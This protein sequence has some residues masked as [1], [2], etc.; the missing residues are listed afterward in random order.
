ME[1]IKMFSWT[2]SGTYRGIRPLFPFRQDRP[3]SSESHTPTAEMPMAS[4][5]GSPGHGQM[6][7]SARPPAPG[8]QLLRVGRCDP[9]PKHPI[10][11]PGMHDPD[12]FDG[13]VVSV[14]E[15]QPVGLRPLLRERIVREVQAGAVLPVG[16]GGE[17]PTRSWIPD[18]VLHRLSAEPPD[19]DV[20]W[21]SALPP[22]NEQPLPRPNEHLRVVRAAG[23]GRQHVDPV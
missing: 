3:P 4:R 7:W 16:D 20:H 6:E 21:T 2:S 15:P 9:G 17:V 18:R 11:L 1:T 23:D 14:G 12:P 13:R 8:C 10:F 22:E 19:S 5:S